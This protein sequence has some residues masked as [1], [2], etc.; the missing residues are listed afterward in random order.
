MGDLSSGTANSIQSFL[1]G[2]VRAIINQMNIGAVSKATLGKPL[3]EELEHI[4]MSFAEHTDTTLNLTELNRD[5]T[6]QISHN[7]CYNRFISN[8]TLQ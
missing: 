1:K 5:C 2:Q 3:Q 8:P 6:V 7:G 4:I